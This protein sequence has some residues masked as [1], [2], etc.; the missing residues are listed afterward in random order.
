MDIPSF[1]IGAVTGIAASK[2]AHALFEMVGKAIGWTL[3]PHRVESLAKAKVV[4]EAKGTIEAIELFKEAGLR[5]QAELVMQ[6]HT[7]VDVANRALPLL[8]NDSRPNEMNLDW[9]RNFY[10]K[11]R[12]TSDEDMKNLWAKI[13]AE[14]ANHPG[15]FSK[16][17]V[18]LVA[19]LDKIDAE[20]FTKAGS[21]IIEMEEPILYVRNAYAT[22]YNRAGITQ[23]VLL[24]LQDAGLL[25]SDGFNGFSLHKPGHEVLFKYFD[26]RVKF[27][28]TGGTHSKHFDFSVFM[29][30]TAGKELFPICGAME[31]PGFLPFLFEEHRGHPEWG[32]TGEVV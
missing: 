4:G 3:E 30:T 24:R 13:L 28:S 11:C 7:L 17:T 29:L 23:T 18:N 26:K 16:R 20:N 8:K 6:Q 22:F 21:F 27:V 19:E 10:D 9:I 14:E 12:L 1:S 5:F 25:S 31:D 15:A 2:S 32:W